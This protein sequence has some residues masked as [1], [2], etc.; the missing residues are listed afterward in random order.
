M[1]IPDEAVATL[2]VTEQ[3]QDLGRQADMIVQ[4]EDGTMNFRIDK[5]RIPSTVGDYTRY[6]CRHIL[7]HGV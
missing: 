3:P 4:L 7:H 5:V 2:R 6:T 1:C